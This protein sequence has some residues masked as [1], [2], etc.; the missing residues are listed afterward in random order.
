[1]V[2]WISLRSSEP[3]F[4]VRVPMGA[5]KEHFTRGKGSMKEL[6]KKI[7]QI[8]KDNKSAPHLEDVEI[9][10]SYYTNG[11]L[12]ISNLNKRDGN[13]TRRELIARFLLLNAVL[14]QGPDMGGVRQLLSATVNRLYEQEIRIL[15]SPLLFFKELGI[16]VNE[17]DTIHELVKKTRE[18]QWRKNNNTKK[19]YNLF[20]DGTT[21]TLAYA[22]FRWGVPLAVPL[23]L[24][25]LDKENPQP[26]LDFLE[27][28]STEFP[29]SA[30]NMSQKIK[31]H[32]K[33]GMGKAI[34][35]KAAH[36][37]AKWLV[38]TYRLT[39]KTDE[40]S[41]QQYSYEVPFDSNAGRVLFRTGFFFHY[42]TKEDLKKKDV[43]QVG[44][45]K[46]GKNYLRITNSRGLKATQNTEDIDFK[47]Y[48]ELCAECLKVS[49][50]PRSIEFQRIPAAILFQDGNYNVGQL[51]DGLMFIGTNY[52]FNHDNPKCEECPLK[53]LCAGYKNKNLIKEYCT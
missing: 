2:K 13:C 33:Y 17:I 12:D 37:F 14:D 42:V 32:K 31:D 22:V 53:N 3:S 7:A 23:A 20:M 35:D 48:I 16:A 40:K 50:R 28:D 45:G 30:E 11:V 26:L 51:D 10:K 44:T 41:W 4:G 38:Y 8:G 49:T 29:S 15:H 47:K 9:F 25:S 24:Q 43:I 6:L 1:M 46:N 19:S 27:K 52:C 5:P 36:L 18:V 39:R 21:Q 34:G